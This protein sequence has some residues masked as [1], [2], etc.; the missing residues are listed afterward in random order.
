[1][2]EDTEPGV[3]ALLAAGDRIFRSGAALG[4]QSRRRR[5]QIRAGHQQRRRRDA[6]L[7]ELGA[8]QVRQRRAAAR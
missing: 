3:A 5:R 6:A 1:A 2:R 4:T 8:R 7:R